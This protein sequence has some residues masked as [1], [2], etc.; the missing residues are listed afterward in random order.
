MTSASTSGA[1]QL[2]GRTPSD[3]LHGLSDLV[4]LRAQRDSGVRHPASSVP[5]SLKNARLIDADLAGLDLSGAD[6]SGAD[7]SRADLTGTRLIGACLVKASLHGTRLEDAE[8]M[9]ADLSE[10]DLS[11][12]VAPRAGFGKANL[13]KAQLFN[14]NFGSATFT[15]AD[16]RGVDFRVADLRGARLVGAQL[17]GA[18]LESVN[19]RGADFTEVK[20][21]G[22]SFRNSDLREARVRGM[23]GYRDADWVGA[24]VRNVDFCGAWLLRRHVLDENFLDEFRRQSDL[25]EWAYK[26]WW[27]TSDCGRSIARWGAW[28]ALV[29][30]LYGGLY[31]LVALDYGN[32]ESWLSPLYFSIVT[33]TTL[34]YGDVLPAS[35]AAQ[36]M[37]LSEVV[38]GYIA[39]GG[40]LSIMA[41]KLARRAD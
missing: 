33:F 28:T 26:L 6:L 23:E 16:L 17:D 20:V 9:A 37:V 35:A 4:N 31:G 5:L 13:H 41:N 40:L 14:A 1:F 32:H 30:V 38:L 27:V 18:I 29:A 36:V 25:H 8:L 19:A 15:G 2:V 10:A 22:A 7:L 21:D 39:L 11:D 34:G 12:A 3:T 24:D